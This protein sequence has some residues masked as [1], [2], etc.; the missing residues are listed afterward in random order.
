M[1][2]N[3]IS[4]VAKKIRIKRKDIIIIIFSPVFL[5]ARSPCLTDKNQIAQG[6][7]TSQENQVNKIL[8]LVS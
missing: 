8:D 6:K 7:N 5:S 2:A 1:L 4:A 3:S